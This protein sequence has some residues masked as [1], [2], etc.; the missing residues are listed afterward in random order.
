MNKIL[1][2]QCIFPVVLPHSEYF[3]SSDQD[4]SLSQVYW[5]LLVFVP[6]IP[7]CEDVYVCNPHNS[8]NI[9]PILPGLNL[10]T[11]QR[12]ISLN[13]YF[14]NVISYLLLLLLF[15]SQFFCLFSNSKFNES[16]KEYLPSNKQSSER[17][18]WLKKLGR[19]HYTLI[20]TNTH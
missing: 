9:R 6:I 11:G 17:V 4:A 19:Q 7:L 20:H 1:C 15:F 2:G 3:H 13:I 16:A 5:C 12:G 10:T 14:F 18:A 8:G